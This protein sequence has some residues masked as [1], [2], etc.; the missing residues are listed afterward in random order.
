MR[1]RPKKPSKIIFRRQIKIQIIGQ[2]LEILFVIDNH[3]IIL[4]IALIVVAGRS[5]TIPGAEGVL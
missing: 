4:E 2:I 1:V 5:R 3:H